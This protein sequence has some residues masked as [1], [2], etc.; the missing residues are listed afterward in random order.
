[1]LVMLYNFVK[2][3]IQSVELVNTT[4]LQF[5]VQFELVF[6]WHKMQCMKLMNT[7]IRTSKQRVK[8]CCVNSVRSIFEE[9]LSVFLSVPSEQN[10]LSLP[11]KTLN[12]GSARRISCL[13]LFRNKKLESE[14]SSYLSFLFV[15]VKVCQ[16]IWSDNSPRTKS[17]FGSGIKRN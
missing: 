6:H 7:R 14:R 11:H 12:G 5:V 15:S 1:M 2:L 17:D 8:L 16:P 13:G 9:A 4:S 3:L 10:L